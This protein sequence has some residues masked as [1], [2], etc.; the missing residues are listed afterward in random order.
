MR[1]LLILVVL[2][3]VL[4]SLARK[5]R[6]AINQSGT[7]IDTSYDWAAPESLLT[8]ASYNI[9]TGKNLQGERDIAKSAH[10]IRQA[11]IVGIQEVYANGWLNMLGFGQAQSVA[12]ANPGRFGQLFAATRYRW[13]RENRGNLLLSR[14]PIDQWDV[15]ML[16]DQ[17]GKSFR[18]MTVANFNWQSE[19]ITIIN[20]HLHTGI[21]REQQLAVVL[22]EF[23]KYPRA[24]LVGDF[25]TMRNADLLNQTLA[26]DSTSDA[27]ALAGLDLKN[28]SRIDWILT[29]GFE[30]VSG[31]M[32]DKGV[33]DHPYYEVSLKLM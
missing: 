16:P 15:V 4:L 12:L 8:I 3:V 10:I 25:N 13:F 6:P 11:D 9:Q 28:A 27:I 23:A 2:A 32:H 26:D 19:P 14:I 29:K 18:N 33:S 21:G 5:P 17:S 24:I 31:K 1:I 22:Q 7:Q 30:I 20:T